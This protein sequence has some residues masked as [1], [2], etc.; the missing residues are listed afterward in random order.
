MP[1]KGRLT[2]HQP[3]PAGESFTELAPNSPGVVRV[4][5]LGHNGRRVLLNKMKSVEF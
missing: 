3:N 1:D 2:P 5:L 4:G